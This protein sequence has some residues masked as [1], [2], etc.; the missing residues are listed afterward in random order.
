MILP[1]IAVGFAV[2]DEL[3]FVDDIAVAVVVETA[4][5][6]IAEEPAA[7]AAAVGT[8]LLHLPDPAVMEAA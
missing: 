1:E 5:Y 6:R 8:D 7:A 3:A 4:A 2:A